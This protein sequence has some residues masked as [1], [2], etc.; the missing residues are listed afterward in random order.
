MAKMMKTALFYV[1]QLVAA[2]SRTLKAVSD[3][4]EL[5][6]RALEAGDTAVA[7]SYEEA[8][9]QQFMSY[10]EGKKAAEDWVESLRAGV[11][12]LDLDPIPFPDV[13]PAGTVSIDL[14]PDAYKALAGLNTWER[15]LSARE[16]KNSGTEE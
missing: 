4:A 2:K 16:E 14:V 10:T 13:E 12:E 15:I 8:A 3:G 11:P 9:Q 5:H 6:R 1:R 7:A